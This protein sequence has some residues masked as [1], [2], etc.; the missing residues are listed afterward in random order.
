[1][2]WNLSILNDLALLKFHFEMHSMPTSHNEYVS[3]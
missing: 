3:E 1:M 2:L